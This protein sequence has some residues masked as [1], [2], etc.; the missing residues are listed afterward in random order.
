MKI[1]KSIDGK[2]VQLIN[3]TIKD[4]QSKHKQ[5]CIATESILKEGQIILLDKRLYWNSEKEGNQIHWLKSIKDKNPKS[6]YSIENIDWIFEAYNQLQLDTLQVHQEWLDKDH[7]N[8]EKIIIE[9]K[10]DSVEN[11]FFISR[12]AYNLGQEVNPTL[13]KFT[14]AVLQNKPYLVEGS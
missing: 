8:Q 13:L 3:N 12:Q 1:E 9:I 11:R 6:T 7:D 2:G 10:N 4:I 5:Y 14:K